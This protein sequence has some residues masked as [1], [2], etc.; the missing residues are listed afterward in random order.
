MSTDS[1]GSEVEPTENITPEKIWAILAWVATA[2]ILLSNAGEKIVGIVK[3][4]KAP[5]AAQNSRLDALEGDMI[6]VKQYLTNDKKAI[7]SLAE[8]DKV[9]KHA[10]LALL[11]HGIDGNNVDEMISS[12]HELET[13]L[14]NR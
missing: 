13:Y 8:G 9:T 14:I 5:D 3:A 10:I 6:L 2:L 11:G 12:K 1:P 4:I 7:D